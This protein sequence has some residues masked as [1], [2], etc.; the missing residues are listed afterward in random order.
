[1]PYDDEASPRTVREAELAFYDAM[2]LYGHE[3]AEALVAERFWKHQ[4]RLVANRIWQEQ[5]RAAQ[6]AK[7]PLH[8]QID[9]T[10]KE[11]VDAFECALIARAL[12]EHAGG[13]RETADALGIAGRMLHEKMKKCGLVR[14]DFQ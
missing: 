7:P 12:E 13:I 9:E 3:S 2:S 1:M 5:R 11:R 6:G 8:G 14:K 10:L 4:R